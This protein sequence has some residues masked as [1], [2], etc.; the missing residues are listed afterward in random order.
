MGVARLRAAGGRRRT[1]RVTCDRI[2]GEKGY[3]WELLRMAEVAQGAD[4]RGFSFSVRFRLYMNVKLE[5]LIKCIEAA[6]AFRHSS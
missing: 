6:G 2:L 3:V 5:K 4:Y 1:W